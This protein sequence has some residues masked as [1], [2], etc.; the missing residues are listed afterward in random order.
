MKIKEVRSCWF[1]FNDAN[2]LNRINTWVANETKGLDQPFT[3]R[4]LP[5]CDDGDS[6][7]VRIE[8]WREETEEEKE[9]RLKQEAAVKKFQEME[10][11]RVYGALWEEYK[12]NPELARLIIENSS[13][14]N[15]RAKDSLLEVFENDRLHT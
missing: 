8:W 9:A 2:V 13:T 15:Q 7:E 10:E 3:T 4:F 12:K 6:L 1:Y 11:K 5:C 14:L